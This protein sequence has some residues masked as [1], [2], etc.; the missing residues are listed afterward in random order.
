MKSL[1]CLLANPDLSEL[2]FLVL[3]NPHCC[4]L[5]A[6]TRQTLISGTSCERKETVI[7]PLPSSMTSE[8]VPVYK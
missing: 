1:S 7:V 2:L 5:S 3:A 6:N 4:E 8:V